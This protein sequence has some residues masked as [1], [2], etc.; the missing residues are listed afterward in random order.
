MFIVNEDDVT[1][2]LLVEYEQ[3][4]Y[5]YRLRVNI[6]LLIIFKSPVLLLKLICV[7]TLDPDELTI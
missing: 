5:I 2:L 7:E 3:F 1:E 4:T 6:E